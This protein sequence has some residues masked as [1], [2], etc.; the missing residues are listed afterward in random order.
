LK[1]I[2]KFPI[3]LPHKFAETKPVP[4][5]VGADILTID[6]QHDQVFIWAVVTPG[7]PMEERHF[8]FYPT[9]LEIPSSENMGRYWKTVHLFNGRLVFHIFE[10]ERT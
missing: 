1:V 3:E 2:H 6:V 5:P 7:S 9:G 4:L 8:N 10:K